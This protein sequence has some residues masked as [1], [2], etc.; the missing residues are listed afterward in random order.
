MKT[1]AV[2]DVLTSLAQVLRAGPNVELQKLDVE[3]S[4]PSKSNPSDIPM[5]LSALAALSQIDKT[6]WRALIDEY[7]LPI[8]V[9]ST[10][11][12]RDI[13]GKI[14]RHLEKDAEA[15]R[16]LKQAAQRSRPDFSP[17]LMNALNFLLK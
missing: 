9:L 1:H 4:G 17:E 15:R 10:E 3:P 6:Q 5:A 14:L 13:V 16:R 12:T 2:A 8:L 7:K 11:S